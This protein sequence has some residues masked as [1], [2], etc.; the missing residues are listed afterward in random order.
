L[1]SRGAARIALAMASAGLAT[2]GAANVPLSRLARPKRRPAL[3]NA[4]H[5]AKMPIGYDAMSS[6]TGRSDTANPALH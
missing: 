2:R 3:T 1:Q 5:R 6:E 4:D